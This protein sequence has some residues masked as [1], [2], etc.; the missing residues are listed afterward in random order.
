MAAQ[1]ALGNMTAETRTVKIHGSEAEKQQGDTKVEIHQ[2]D[3]KR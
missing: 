1:M 3:M 2:G